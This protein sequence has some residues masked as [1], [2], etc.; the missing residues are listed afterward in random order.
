MTKK[1]SSLG[2]GLASILGSSTTNI[3]TNKITNEGK[4]LVAGASNEVLISQN[5]NEY[6]N[7]RN[8]FD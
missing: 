3:T 4:A 8:Q 6:G 7:E 5:R 1:K 2:R